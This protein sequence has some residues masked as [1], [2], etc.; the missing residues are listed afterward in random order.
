MLCT[1]YCSGALV[2]RRASVGVDFCAPGHRA[3]PRRAA[4]GPWLLRWRRRPAAAAG[5]R[6]AVGWAV[7]RASY[8]VIYTTTTSRATETHATSRWCGR[9]PS[10]RVL[11]HVLRHV[12]RGRAKRR[13]NLRGAG[14]GCRVWLTTGVE[15]GRARAARERACAA[16]GSHHAALSVHALP[17]RPSVFA[18]Q[19]LV[20]EMYRAPIG[21]RARHRGG[22]MSPC[23]GPPRWRPPDADEADGAVAAGIEGGACADCEAD[24]CTP[25]RRGVAS[26]EA[27]LQHEQPLP[28]EA[29]LTVRMLPAARTRPRSWPRPPRCCAAP[30]RAARAR[31]GGR[32]FALANSA[33]AAAAVAARAAGRGRGRHAASEEWI[34]SA[35]VRQH[36]E[37]ALQTLT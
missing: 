23:I 31:A 36:M 18:R 25:R 28:R 14:A 22:S 37:R 6:P 17:P 30:S 33:A 15:S 29:L 32:R 11:R 7:G 1:V 12:L 3:T 8:G 19:G 26:L 2:R 34:D 13:S 4:G 10:P 20:L 5:R 9:E 16:G 27:S 21:H 35:R 24:D